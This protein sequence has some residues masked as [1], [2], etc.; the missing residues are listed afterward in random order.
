MKIIYS[1]GIL[2]LCLLTACQSSLQLAGSQHKLV[3]DKWGELSAYADGTLQEFDIAIAGQLLL[4]GQS[5]DKFVLRN[6]HL[7]NKIDI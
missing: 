6:F 1:L 7:T 5:K 3:V 4:E 2:L